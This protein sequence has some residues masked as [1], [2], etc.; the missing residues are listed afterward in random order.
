MTI[1]TSKISKTTVIGAATGL[2]VALKSV[3]F[4]AAG[5]LAMT[6]KDWFSLGIG[7]VIAWVGYLQCDAK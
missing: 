2:V 5:H 3:Q 1:D 7:A 6:A 4:D